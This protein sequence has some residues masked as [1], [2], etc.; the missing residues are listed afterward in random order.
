[1]GLEHEAGF[2]GL[3]GNEALFELFFSPFAVCSDPM[4]FVHFIICLCMNENRD[5]GIYVIF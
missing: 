2:I 4:L 5:S 1:M 3:G